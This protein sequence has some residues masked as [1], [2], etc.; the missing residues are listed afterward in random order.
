MTTLIEHLQA[1][2]AKLLQRY[3]TLQPLPRWFFPPIVLGALILAITVALTPGAR[4]LDE[5]PPPIPV[6]VQVIQSKPYAPRLVGFGEVQPELT[7]QAVAQVAGR[8]TY[9]HPELKSGALISKGTVILTIDPLDYELLVTRAEATLQAAEAILAEF[10]SRE[11]D[12]KQSLEIEAQSLI[13]SQLDLDRKRQLSTKGHVSAL[14]LAAEE[15]K[16]LRSQQNVQN[17]KSQLNL[18]PIQQNAQL[19]RVT[20][21]KMS[22]ARATED[23]KRTRLVMPFDARV[24]NIKLAESQFVPIGQLLATAESVNRMEVLL[25]VP[26]AQMTSRF[27]HIMASP[28]LLSSP[29]N[30]LNA[31]VSYTANGLELSWQGKVV[32]I[33]PALNEKTR[34]ARIYISISRESDSLPPRAHL[35]TR[36]EIT[37]PDLE[38]QIVIPRLA[39]HEGLVYL[40]NQSSQMEFREVTVAFREGDNLIIKS[41]L[42]AG[43]RIILSDLPFPI[44]GT[45]VKIATESTQDSSP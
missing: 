35:Y 3:A 33:D 37:G 1:T 43:E 29:G 5:A 32:R 4:R 44:A 39:Y 23:V 11:V 18:L 45:H 22:V 12:L 20:E 25:E 42:F 31:T 21:A 15:Q 38:E 19:A 14:E 8:I 36:I 17:L 10:P 28:E 2:T 34:A 40:V 9:R 7:W 26:V 6:R 16:L 24:T 30:T 27:P 13:L 41:G